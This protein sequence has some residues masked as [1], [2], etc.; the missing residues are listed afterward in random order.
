GLAWRLGVLVA[1]ELG[2][3]TE[4]TASLTLML[5]LG[6]LLG[7]LL[8]R[9]HRQ[10]LVSSLVP[11]GSAYVLAAIFAAPLVA[12]LAIGATSGPTAPRHST[13]YDGD[14]ANVVVP[15]RHIALGG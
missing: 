2:I 12:Y 3:S 15:T 11:I 9:D 14:L 7:L 10:R 8:L 1:L 4:V 5:V 13:F 6:L